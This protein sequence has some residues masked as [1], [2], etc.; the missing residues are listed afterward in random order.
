MQDFYLKHNK[1]PKHIKYT[2]QIDEDLYTDP[3][4]EKDGQTRESVAAKIRDTLN[5]PRGWRQY[6]YTFEEVPVNT[7]NTPDELILNI[8]LSNR[9]RVKKQCSTGTLSCY[10]PSHHSIE[11]LYDNWMTG[12]K[13]KLP[14]DRYRT[15]VI[16]HEVGHSLGLQ[17]SKCPGP[18]Q[19][20]SI[21]QQ[22]SR[23][24]EHISPCI[25]NEWPLP[26][27]TFDE[28]QNLGLFDVL[29]QKHVTS[30]SSTLIFIILCI[31]LVCILCAGCQINKLF[32]LQKNDI[33]QKWWAF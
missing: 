18:G 31:V 11:I 17:H 10:N 26:V 22:M 32:N 4:L 9:E 29:F 19:K 28:M 33:L 24:P 12:F 25:E 21:M 30:Y 3:S 6:G 5:D 27:E 2:F 1:L 20:G 16:C 8:R 13:S 14:I 23:G 15:Y 7:P